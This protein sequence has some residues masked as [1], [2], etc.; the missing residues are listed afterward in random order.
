MSVTPNRLLILAIAP[1]GL[2]LLIA[3]CGGGDAASATGTTPEAATPAAASAALGGLP[4]EVTAC[5]ED[6]GLATNPGAGAGGDAEFQTAIVECA[7][8]A[9]VELPRRAGNGGG[10]FANFDPAALEE[11]LAS[12]GIEV[13]R[14]GEADGTTARGGLLDSLDQDDPAVTAALEV[15]GFDPQNRGARQ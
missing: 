11:C 3:A 10:G 2:V 14:D 1:L 15:C 5:L 8:A 7:E 13:D 6:R 9:S 12:E 4:A